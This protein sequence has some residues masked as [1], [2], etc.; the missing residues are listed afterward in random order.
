M[1][2]T[3]YFE[4]SKDVSEIVCEVEDDDTLIAIREEEQCI[5]DWYTGGW[6]S[7]EEIGVYGRIDAAW[8]EYRTEM[9]EFK[10]RCERD[11]RIGKR[12]LNGG[13]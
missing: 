5:V 3:L 12:M 10:A 8:A 4:T 13:W 6:S 7:E 1:N 11:D 2:F 9:E